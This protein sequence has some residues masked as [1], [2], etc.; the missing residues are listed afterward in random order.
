MVSIIN[1]AHRSVA[2]LKRP[3]KVPALITYSQNVVKGMTGNPHFPTPP[4]AL[5]QLPGAIATL[6]AAE[7]ATLTRVAGSVAARNTARSALV[8]LLQQLLGN[9]QVAADADM[10]NGAAIIQSTGFAVR[11]TPVR[12]PR[13]FTAV[14]GP[15]TGSAKL[16]AG[17]VSRRASYEWEYSPDGGKT[18][19]LSTPTLQ[20]RTV[21]TGLPAGTTVQFRYRGVTKTGVADWSAPVSLLVK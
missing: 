7:T 2:I 11:K 9:V 6:S 4:P 20:T 8:L 10:E 19:I 3:A 13:V 14:A 18:W 16:S 5:A 21:V 17:A 12:A 1:N 15:T